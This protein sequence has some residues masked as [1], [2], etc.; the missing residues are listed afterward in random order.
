VRDKIVTDNTRM[1]SGD[2][3]FTREVIPGI[4]FCNRKINSENPTLADIS[5]TILAAFGIKPPAF[6]DGKDL[7]VSADG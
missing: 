2:H 4:F 3:S 5:P 7:Q 6:I 1:W